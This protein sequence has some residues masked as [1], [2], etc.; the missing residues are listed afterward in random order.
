M[1]AVNG[2][3]QPL[4]SRRRWAYGAYLVVATTRIPARTGYRLSNVACNM[5]VTSE[6][7]G[8]SLTKLPHIILFGAF[9]LLTAAQFDRLDPRTLTWSVAATVALGVL[10]EIEEGATRTGNCRMTDV[11]PDLCGALIAA[12]LIT[13]IAL[14]QHRLK[15]ALATRTNR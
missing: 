15:E 6:N 12:V 3:L 5:R 13:S 14:I 7:V 10:V 9:F 1:G 11:L 4:W 8:L 2:T